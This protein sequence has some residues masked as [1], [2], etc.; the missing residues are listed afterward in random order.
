[1][2]LTMTGNGQEDKQM[3]MQAG[4]NDYV[5]KTNGHENFKSDITKILMKAALFN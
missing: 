3:A 2:L 4:M 5:P 1:M